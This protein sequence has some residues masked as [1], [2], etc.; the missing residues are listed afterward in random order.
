MNE[1]LNSF[2]L[3]ALHNSYGNVINL[4]FETSKDVKDF[5]VEKNAK[6]R[7]IEFKPRTILIN[8]F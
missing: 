6:Q 3:D 1:A 7:K 8:T 4:L 2:N 5:K